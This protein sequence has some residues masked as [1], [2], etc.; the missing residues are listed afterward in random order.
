[1]YKLG[2]K[3]CSNVVNND[4]AWPLTTETEKVYGHTRHF[5]TLYTSLELQ[6]L[7]NNEREAAEDEDCRN[8]GPCM[9]IELS[10]NN[11]IQNFMQTD[12][13]TTHFATG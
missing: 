7:N 4:H 3:A 9:A 12:Y 1:L 13:F 2:I 5:C 6:F 8:K 11:I 10:F